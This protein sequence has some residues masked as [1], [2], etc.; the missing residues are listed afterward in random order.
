M[1]GECTSSADP[2]AS[3]ERGILISSHITSDLEKIADYIVCI[4][5]GRIVFAVEKD[6][7]TETAGIARCRADQFARVR[8]DATFGDMR[9]MTHSYGTDILVDDR[10][11]FQE[12][13]P[14]ITVDRATIDEYMS[15]R[16]KGGIR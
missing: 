13:F 12:S 4:D 9:F 7:I 8:E 1:V 2:G 11:A 15:L 14:D 3:C 10:F 6:A 5:A 16:L